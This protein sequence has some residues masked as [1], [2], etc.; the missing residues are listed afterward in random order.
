MRLKHN[1]ARQPTHPVDVSEPF[2]LRFLFKALHENHSLR[3]ATHQ[4]TPTSGIVAP[5]A[6]QNGSTK[7]ATRPSAVRVIQNIFRS[8]YSV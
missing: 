3:Y 1:H 4:L 5:S 8:M 2:Q 6:H 7:S